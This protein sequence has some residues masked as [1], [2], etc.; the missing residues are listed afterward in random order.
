LTSHHGLTSKEKS[1]VIPIK[2]LSID[3]TSSSKKVQASEVSSP[4][5]LLSPHRPPLTQINFV[6]PS[7]VALVVKYL[8]TEEVKP[9]LDVPS[10]WKSPTCSPTSPSTSLNLS[11]NYG[12]KSD[13]MLRSKVKI[14]PIWEEV[15]GLALDST[16]RGHAGRKYRISLASIVLG[17]QKN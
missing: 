9:F 1:H 17:S 10:F 2:S 12:I 15:G 14:G 4:L 16:P 5:L 11:Q 8:V 7:I 6:S 3:A 13:Y